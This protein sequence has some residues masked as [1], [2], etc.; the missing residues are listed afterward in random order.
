MQ[1]TNSDKFTNN[2]DKDFNNN[3]ISFNELENS[4]TPY[5]LN[6][7]TYK[8]DERIKKYIFRSKSQQSVSCQSMCL[9]SGTRLRKINIFNRIHVMLLL[10]LIYLLSYRLQNFLH[11]IIHVS[12]PNKEN[13]ENFFFSRMNNSLEIQNLNYI[14]NILQKDINMRSLYSTYSIDRNKSAAF[15]VIQLI[16]QNEFWLTISLHFVCLIGLFRR[17]V[18]NSTS[19]LSNIQ[20]IRYDL[21]DMSACS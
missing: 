3:L 2:I 7:L 21:Y 15:E 6:S 19:L 10:I 16:Q 8:D 14:E 9:Q 12:R 13:L 1:T 11:N 20:Q 18:K 17:T 5:R 4:S